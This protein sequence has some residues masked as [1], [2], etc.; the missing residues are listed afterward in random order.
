MRFLRSRLA[1]ICAPSAQGLRPRLTVRAAGG[2]IGSNTDQRTFQRTVEER[3][4]FLAGAQPGR[5]ARAPRHRHT[6]GTARQSGTAPAQG[7]AELAVERGI[8]GQ[9]L[10][11]KGGLQ[12]T[13]PRAGRRA[14]S[15]PPPRL[16]VEMDQFGDARRDRHWRPPQ[17]SAAGS[18]SAPKNTGCS[19]ARPG[20]RALA[21]LRP[22]P[23]VHR[24]FV[25][26]EPAGRQRRRCQTVQARGRSSPAISAPS[27]S[28][29][30]LPHIGSSRAAP[31]A[32]I[33]GQAPRSSIAAA[34]FSFRR[35]IALRLPPTAA[36]QGTA[37]EIDGDQGPALADDG[38]DAQVR[39]VHVHR[40]THAVGGADAIDDRVL[41]PLRGIT[42]MGD[43]RAGHV[44]V[45]R[46][47]ALGR[48]VV[49]QSI[50]CT[51][52]YRSCSFSQAKSASGHNTRLARRENIAAR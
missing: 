48:D 1:T 27:I 31:S 51:P 52:W 25:E 35:R 36:M 28:R 7:V 39:R 21:W 18:R 8:G 32:W 11:C 2:W 42:L 37:A 49:I 14:P 24:A 3:V 13:R 19:A 46:Q 9:A 44:G 34:R 15:A 40:R 16:A 12:T 26:A 20:L 29:V 5:E 33:F 47:R 30:P 45:H 22:P 50:A 38:I 23:P 17:C 4:Y 10:R 41:D 6:A 43:R